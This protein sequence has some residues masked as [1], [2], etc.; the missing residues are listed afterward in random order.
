MPYKKRPAKKMQNKKRKIY[1]GKKTRVPKNIRSIVKKEIVKM[2]AKPEVKRSDLTYSTTDAVMGQCTGN[3][4]GW[5]G[6]E[7]TPAIAQGSGVSQRVGNR[8]NVMSAYMTIQLRQMSGCSHPT[9]IKFQMYYDPT[10]NTD[11]ISTIVDNL[12]NYNDYIGGGVIYDYNSTRNLDY[13]TD[14]KLVRTWTSVLRADSVSS[15]LNL[16]TYG[17]GFKF[18]KPKNLSWFSTGSTNNAVGRFYLVAFADSGNCST[19]TASTLS[20]APVTAI[21]TGVY[22]NYSIK[23]YYTDP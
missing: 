4:N 12:Y 3:A 14:M 1:R 5:Y 18:K 7:I 9:K 23:W 17:I 21:N 20:N 19:T 8:V 6:A 11:T 2:G 13:L 16:K 15:Q 22:I 10:N